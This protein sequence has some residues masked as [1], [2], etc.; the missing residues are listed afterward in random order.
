MIDSTD[1][2]E[3]IRKVV[4]VD[5]VKII[6]KISAHV[7][8]FDKA[9]FLDYDEVVIESTSKIEKAPLS[10]CFELRTANFIERYVESKGS[11][12]FGVKVTQCF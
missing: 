8:L 10:D 11:P 9:Y 3:R 7:T 5:E 1:Y 6:G 2:I 12:H 4:H